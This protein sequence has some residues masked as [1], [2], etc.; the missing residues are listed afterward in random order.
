MRAR[1][2]I[3]I[4]ILFYLY[5]I[6]MRIFLFIYFIF[7]FYLRTY[8][9]V[10]AIL[11]EKN[12]GSHKI[13]KKQKYFFSGFFGIYQIFLIIKPVHIPIDTSIKLFPCRLQIKAKISKKKIPRYRFKNQVT[14][15]VSQR[16]K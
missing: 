2:N 8:S 7:I 13:L 10:L 11:S 12:I 9:C 1:N 3:K 4:T 15:Q 16:Y 5:F 6:Y 14:N